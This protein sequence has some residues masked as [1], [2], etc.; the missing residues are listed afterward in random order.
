MFPGGI[1]PWEIAV[2]VIIALL[3]FGPSKLPE[4]GK[5][6]GRGIREFRRASRE[7]TRDL[8]EA[9]DDVA[10]KAEARADEER[11]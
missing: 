11:D 6:L 2:V 1:G 3:V 8:E 5:A 4:M 10:D 9:A 7:I